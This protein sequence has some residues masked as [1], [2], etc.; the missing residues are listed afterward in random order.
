MR[1]FILV[2]RG[3]SSTP[4]KTSLQEGMQTWFRAHIAFMRYSR[5]GHLARTWGDNKTIWYH[6]VV[7]AFTTAHPLQTIDQRSSPLIWPISTQRKPE[8]MRLTP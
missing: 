2:S 4:L 7:S 1:F 3:L 5:P 8:R 6:A